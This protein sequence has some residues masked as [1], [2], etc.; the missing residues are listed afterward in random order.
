[1]E[2]NILVIQLVTGKIIC[3]YPEQLSDLFNELIDP[4]EIN[5]ANTPSGLAIN[6]LPLGHFSGKTRLLVE[7]EAILWS[8]EAK[9]TMIDAYKS[10]LRDFKTR[11]GNT[12]ES[13][14]IVPEV[15]RIVLK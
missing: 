9:E 15:G 2:Q 8:V 14:I 11:G 6:F 3:K 10:A 12:E 7:N 4:C 13:D 1:M 5:Y